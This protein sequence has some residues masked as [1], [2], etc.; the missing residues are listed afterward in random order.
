VEEK[1]WHHHPMDYYIPYTGATESSLHHW[2]GA[3]YSD[4]NMKILQHW[5]Q[6]VAKFQI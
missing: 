3:F 1:E 5:A 2:L 4:E 6:T